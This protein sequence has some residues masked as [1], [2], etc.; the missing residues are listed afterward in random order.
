MHERRRDHG[1]EAPDTGCVYGIHPVEELL[2]E[3]SG[4]V[5]RLHFL[6][7]GGSKPLGDLVARAK[8][9][10]IP[11]DFCNRA[12]LDALAG[13]A[14][15]QGV[16]AQVAAIPYLPL[17]DLIARAAGDAPGL[18]VVLDEVSDP[19]NLGAV[20]RT[21][22]AA[23]AHGIIIPKRRAAPA[24]DLVAKVSAGAFMHLPL[25]R[26]DNTV[27]ALERLKQAGYWVYGLAADGPVNIAQADFRAA[28]VLVLGAEGKGLRPLVAR[29][30]D[31]LVRI[32]LKG[33]TPSLNVSV[34]AAV[35]IFAV[36]GQ[37]EGWGS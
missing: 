19:R 6:D 27:Q 33:R 7:G 8:A 29:H 3:G 25:T 18:I 4:R 36:I 5:S 12:R 26:V 31:H 10:A 23:G 20:M 16:V 24:T 34:A 1:P 11:F 32:P 15:H 9:L 30:C 21:A 2:A 14:K 17:D 13:T 37:R 28:T 35:A 22:E